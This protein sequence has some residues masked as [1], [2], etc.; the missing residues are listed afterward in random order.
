MFKK[1][2]NQFIGRRKITDESME[3]SEVEKLLSGLEET[4]KINGTYDYGRHKT[5]KE[6]TPVDII[7]FIER[8]FKPNKYKYCE[9]NHQIFSREQDEK[10]YIGLQAGSIRANIGGQEI[11]GNPLTKTALEYVL[12]K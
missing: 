7:K 3:F 6:V 2:K 8:E 4:T 1:I 9:A 12:K 11:R 10:H 5:F